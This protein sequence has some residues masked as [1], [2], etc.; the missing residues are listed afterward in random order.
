[1]RALIRLKNILFVHLPVLLRTELIRFMPFLYKPLKHVPSAA[2]LNPTDNCNMRCIMCN[3]WRETKTGELTLDEWKDLFRQLKAVGVDKIGFNGGEPLLRKDI[4]EMI[5]EVSDLGMTP[6][7]ITSGYLLTEEKLEDLISAGLRHITVSIDGVGEEYERIR[8]REWD[9]VE[10]A[11]RRV[12]KAFSEDRIDANI[13]FVIMNETLSHLPKIRAF[14]KELGL[15]LMF[16]LVDSTPFFFKIPEN[17][18]TA[19]DTNWVPKERHPQLGMLQR[20]LVEMKRENHYSTVNTYSDINYMTSYF[21]DPLQAKIPCTVSQLRIMINGM[22][23]VYGGCWSM[24]TYG[25]IREKPLRDI[26]SSDKYL[27]AHEAMFHKKCPGCSC[28]YTTNLRYSM[29][30]QLQDRMFN[31]LPS[32]RESIGIFEE[33]AT[34][35]S[36]TAKVES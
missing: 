36:G 27:R 34:N 25:N 24:G 32:T 31:L 15:P 35:T 17:K 6:A 23:E 10:A 30:L 21:Q 29:P 1:M 18:R 5:R 3:Q 8:R 33:V 22:G 19:Q 20:E 13:G 28:G 4:V 11:A 16:S 9:R 12:S 26:L 7:I 14:C 2:W